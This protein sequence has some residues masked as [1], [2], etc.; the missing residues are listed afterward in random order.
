MRKLVVYL[1]DCKMETILAPLFKLLEATLELFVP[2][3]IARMIDVG[4]YHKDTAYV[5]RM[6]FVL[7]LLGAVG[8]GFSVTA[9]YFAA[10]AAV[11]FATKVR[12]ALFAHIEE[13][14]YS[15]IDTVKTSTLITRMTSDLNQVQSGVNMTLRLLLRS[16]FIVFGAMIMAFTIDL[17]AAL[18]FVVTIP[19][20]SVVVFAVMIACIPLYRKVQKRLDAVTLS[21]RE[22]LAGVRVIRAFCRE[23]KEMEFFRNKNEALTDEQKLVGRIMAVMNPATYIVLNAGIIA[24]IYTGAVRVEH[25]VLTQGALVALYNYMTQILEELIKLANLIVNITKSAACANRIADVLALKSSMPKTIAKAGGKDGDGSVTDVDA[26]EG[27]HAANAAAAHAKDSM[28]SGRLNH[29]EQIVVFDHVSLRYHGSREDALSDVNLCIRRNQTI[30]IIGGTGS[31]KSSLINLIPRFYDVT[32]GRLLIDG[33]DI[34]QYDVTALRERI[35][36]VPQKAVLFKGSIRDNMKWGRGDATDEEI[37]EALRIAQADTIVREKEGQLDYMLL[38][39]GR[40]LSGGQRQRLTI[41]RALVKKPDILI[42]DDSASALDFVT[43]KA[44]RTALGTLSDV[45]VFIV[46]QRTSSIR[47]ADQI[48]VLEDGKVEGVGTHDGLLKDCRVYQEIYASQFRK[49]D[50]AS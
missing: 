24:L 26:G 23:K 36:V 13:L 50:E 22:N 20:L 17:K 44:L 48:L 27:K 12:H 10:K 28:P 19:A 14:S 8:L 3:V 35:G 18:V 25:G 5:I 32:G 45:T 21:T 38:S 15:E 47:H 4:I 9:Q 49:E 31:G 16:P 2:L 33:T 37:W 42:L 40:N 39:G 43:D 46:S 30:G 6:C 11:S 41:A 7:I 29:A 1:K 34:S